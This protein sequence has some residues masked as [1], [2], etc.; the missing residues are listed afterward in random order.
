MPEMTY[1]EAIRAAMHDEME[2][3]ERVFVMGEDVGR[4]GGAFGATKELQQRFGELRSIDT[5]V[6]ESGIVGVAVGA[7]MAG[8]RP[9]AE[10]QFAD[11]VSCAYDQLITCAA[12][13]HYRI[14]WAVPLVV[15]CPNGGG[16]GGGPYHSEN[17]EAWFHHHAGLKIVCPATATDAYGLLRSAIRD[18]NPV[19]FCEHKFLYRRVKQ[20]V[21]TGPRDGVLVPLGKADVVREG[22]D[23]SIITYA[24]TVQLALAVADTLER[25]DV[26]VEVIDLR[27]LV[28]FD[29][30][31]VLDSVRKTG[32][33]ADRARGQ[34]DRRV[35]RRGGGRDRT[36]RVRVPG[37]TG[38]AGGG[39]GHA[40]PVRAA[41]GARVPAA[42]RG[43]SRGGAGPGR[44]L[45][46]AGPCP[47]FGVLA[48]GRA[49]RIIRD[50]VWEGV[51]E[52]V[53]FRHKLS[54]VLVGLA[55]V[56]LIG[57]GLIV[58][59]LLTRDTVRSVDAKLSIGAA[60]AAA[61]YR[62]Q[63]VVA[64]TV[65]VQLAS[66]PDVA[67][68]FRD[69]DASQLDLSS[70]SAGLLRGSGRRQGHVRRVGADG[71]GLAG[72]RRAGPPH[73]RPARDRL[74]AAQRRAAAAGRGTE[75]AARRRRPGAGQRRPRDRQPRSASAVT[76]AVSHPGR[77]PATARSATPLCAPRPCASV[78]RVRR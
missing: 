75:P 7:A 72:Q 42:R 61:A 54:I 8:Q 22:S 73:G 5:P 40:D 12:K 64:Q 18:P 38:A 69:R 46:I 24:S 34:P 62:S 37:C 43:H 2:I 58:Q 29:R 78:G 10:M 77:R 20:Q 36:G 49:V 45:I 13:M 59:A 56:P 14:G 27:T 23:L 70:R 28:P 32:Q 39:A 57:A 9:I 35:R 50:W 21:A 33:G 71:P 30:D 74:D 16:V 3:D 76:S 65:A 4:Q 26:S 52:S 68:A 60:G 11:F 41:A 53:R 63:Q 1:L 25:E 44:L 51:T 67:R 66:R 48:A 19:V 6:A 31:T 15:R 17:V 55:L 47:P